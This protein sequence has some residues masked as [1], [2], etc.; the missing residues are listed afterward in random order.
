MKLGKSF[1]GFY[2]FR[3]SNIS[4]AISP[5]WDLLDQE[6]A[7]ERINPQVTCLPYILLENGRGFDGALSFASCFLKVFLD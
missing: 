6:I 2:M 4:I 1:N 3:F 7:I 5:P